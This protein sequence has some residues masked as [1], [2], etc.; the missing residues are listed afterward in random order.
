MRKYSID[1]A[2]HFG[3][4][5]QSGCE[6]ILNLGKTTAERMVVRAVVTEA[7]TGSTGLTLKVQGSDDGSTG[8]T[9]IA[10]TPSTI[11]VAKCVAGAE[12]SLP[13]P[14]EYGKQYLK[15]VASGP[16]SIKMEAFLDCYVGI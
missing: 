13:I 2:L 6:N 15:V 12:V 7:A 10:V 14:E 1:A 9:D 3:E 16:T 11:A 4:V 8:W 5:T